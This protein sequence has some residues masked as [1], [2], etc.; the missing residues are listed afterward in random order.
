LNF[1]P[2]AGQPN[3]F[4]DFAALAVDK[5]WTGIIAFNVQIDGNQMEP[6]FQMLLGGMQSDL[7][8]HHIG[9]EANLLD[10]ATL[11]INQSS[12]FGVICYPP[13]GVTPSPTPQSKGPDDVRYAVT[14][15]VVVF[16]N[17]VVTLFE[18]TAELIV[19]I[20]FGRPVMSGPPGNAIP[21]QGQYQVHNG[22]GTITFQSTQEFDF[23][24]ADPVHT[25]ILD[26]LEI[27]RARFVP[28][29][30]SSSGSSTPAGAA[31]PPPQTTVR[32]A[33]CLE[34]ELWF[35]QS[36][37]PGADPVDLFSYGSAT[38][39]MAY[40]GLNVD[41]VFTLDPSG[42]ASAPTVTVDYPQ[43]QPSPD[44]DAV[45]ANSLLHSLPAQFSRFLAGA[46]VSK[47]AA[48]S[49]PIHCNQLVGTAG[50]G[51]AGNPLAPLATYSPTFALEY[52]VSLGSLGS[53][54]DGQGINA[55][56]L[57]G[58]GSSA[59]SPKNDAGGLLMQLPQLSAGI[60]GIN[61]EGVLQ[62]QLGIGNLARVTL[63]NG[64]IAYAILFNN[65]QLSAIGLTL[66]TGILADVLI[67]SDTTN[68]QSNLAWFL[69]A[70]AGTP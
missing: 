26:K 10:P 22:V 14:E 19:N 65:A 52:D 48:A 41:I 51:T 56:L 35:N 55:K 17:S 63:A 23:S 68:P 38:N 18:A 12:M 47:A 49:L 58:W 67:F 15:L 62:V 43:L 66:P 36:P 69:A 8:A 60:T 7:R 46:D 29:T 44:P 20:I 70:G 39:G 3:P 37:F 30:G 50:G 33:F 53:L 24:F 34:G 40:T 1:T 11:A 31:L 54:A 28:I 32:C 42:S 21:I 16:R 45:R 27:N 25:R 59:F 2:K 9:I 6:D 57:I 4:T 61:I 64:D 5:T 13:P